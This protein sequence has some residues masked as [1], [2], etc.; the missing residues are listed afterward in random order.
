MSRSSHQV[1]L[2]CHKDASE[3]AVVAAVPVAEFN[4]FDDVHHES[5]VP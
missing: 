3:I 2:V 5:V 4:P 1:K